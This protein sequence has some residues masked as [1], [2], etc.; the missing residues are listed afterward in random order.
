MLAFFLNMLTLDYLPNHIDIEE[1]KLR[2][3]R[4]LEVSKQ[5][6]LNYYNKYLDK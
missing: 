2:A 3:R 6:E 4:L 5:L 1:K